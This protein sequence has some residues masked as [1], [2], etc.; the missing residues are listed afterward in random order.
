MIDRHKFVEE[1]KL[2]G[3]IRKAVRIIQER[4]KSRAK[5]ALLEEQ[6]LRKFIRKLLVEADTSKPD[7]SPH[8][9][10]GIN[11]LE[12]LLHNIIKQI[13]DDFMQLTTSSEQRTS[14]RRHLIYN[15]MG[16]LKPP[17]VNDAAPEGAEEK[18][19]PISEQENIELKVG[20]E[21]GDEPMP[22]EFIP[23]ADPD[24]IP[25]EPS[26]EE[27]DLT[28]FGIP[29]EDE[30]GRDYAFGTFEQVSTQILKAYNK[31][32]NQED[33]DLFYDY[34]KTNLQLYFDKFEKEIAVNLPEPPTSPEYE[35][36]KED[37][38]PPVAE[39]AMV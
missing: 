39:E 2:R 30:T 21:G 20:T 10:T 28:A 5:E 31:L 1:I 38:G 4:R 13:K 33:K 24:D 15:I 37:M 6:K 8:E 23:G 34:L 35:A 17:A 14:F 18:F 27:K 36:A 16:L 19:I 3:Q 26:E 25:E 12:D 22:P 32:G 9:K 7:E 11:A 29:G